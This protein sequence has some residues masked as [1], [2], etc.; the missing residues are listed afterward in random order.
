MTSFRGWLERIEARLSLLP[1][2]LVRADAL[3]SR[4]EELIARTDGVAARVDDG[5]R[6]AD[7]RGARLGTVDLSL[8]ASRSELSELLQRQSD[9]QLAL[10]TRLQS[11]SDGIHRV[12]ESA[13]THRSELQALRESND[14]LMRELYRAVEDRERMRASLGRIE[15]RQLSDARLD[16]AEFSVY[17]QGGE[18]GILQRLCQAMPEIPKTFVEFGVEDYR[19]A[20]TRFLLLS[21]GWRG[22]VLDGSEENVARIRNG[23]AYWHAD[24]TA[25]TAFVTREN[26]DDLLTANG[27][28]GELGVLS[29]DIDGNDYWVWEAISVVRPWIVSVE[30]NWRFGPDRAVTV[31]YRPDFERSRA[32][33]S[34]L[35]FG[36]SLAALEKLAERK[37]YALVAATSGAV[38][39]FFVEKTRIPVGLPTR[40]ARELW[41]SGRFSEA[42]DESGNMVKLTAEAQMRLVESLPV[43]EV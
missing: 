40:T 5:R 12:E 9:Y 8:E 15:A 18:D 37:G 38:N 25:E 13:V 23:R 20:N 22:L 41:R 10:E 34:W 24:L 39:A 30:F 7:Q 17:S 14:A 27:F 43:V 32:N 3:A 36:A 1:T 33:P 26:I 31:P 4:L 2:L 16:D 35:Y 28:S 19:E 6:E 21:G 29:I 42:R 11:L